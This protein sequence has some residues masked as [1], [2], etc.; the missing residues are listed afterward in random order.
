MLRTV[1]IGTIAGRSC[2]C[3][4]SGTNASA[5][6]HAEQGQSLSRTGGGGL[7]AAGSHVQKGRA[8]RRLYHESAMGTT[9]AKTLRTTLPARAYTDPAWFQREMEAIFARMWLAAGRDGELQAPGA[10]VRR[11]V[12][13]ASV[14]IVRA[15]E[16]LAA[17]IPQRV[18][19]PR[20]ALVHGGARHASRD[21]SSARITRGPTASTAACWRRRRWT[22]SPAS[23][24]PTIRFA[25]SRATSWDGH[26]FINLSR[27]RPDA[28]CPRRSATC[29]RGLRRG[30]CRSCGW[31]GGSSTTSPPTGS[32][33]C[34][35]TT[36]ACIA[37]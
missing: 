5:W 2:A 30:A 6:N 13:G 36:S 34:R 25:R 26:I 16:R 11:D 17:R 31:C 35:T 15:D 32:S 19:A 23:I 9:A 33:W 18:P 20:H 22:R 24:A 27:A 37:R 29:P 3:A 4:M 8:G 28:R 10:F 21:A 7:A 14:L 12:A 1:A